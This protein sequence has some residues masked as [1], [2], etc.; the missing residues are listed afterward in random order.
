MRIK[1]IETLLIVT[2]LLAFTS[3]K[4]IIFEER[5]DCPCYLTLDL[6]S[7][8][9]TMGELYLWAYDTEG[10]LILTDTILPIN[11]GKEYEVEIKRTTVDYYLWGN[12][13]SSTTLSEDD[14]KNLTLSKVDKISADSLYCYASEAFDANDEL[15]RD[16][17]TLQKEYAKLDILIKRAEDTTIE[18]ES[19]NNGYYI[20]NRVIESKSRWLSAG[21]LNADG[22]MLHSF[23]ITRQSNL[24]ELTL[25]LYGKL[26]NLPL[27]LNTYPIGEWLVAD[28]YT[29]SELSLSDIYVEVDSSNNY[30][31]IIVGDWVFTP[32]ADVEI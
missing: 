30:I 25:T 22:D 4:A 20:D 2:T 13:G 21:K 29:M 1:L 16:T 7:V 12:I 15:A 32:E 24:E 27:V 19:G 28:G 26:N 8:P 14:T 31:T 17:I 23:N 18:V 11:F 3:C 9:S 10:K 6:S 5:E